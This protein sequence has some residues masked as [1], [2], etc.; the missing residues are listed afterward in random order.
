MA[1]QVSNEP[2][3]FRAF[4]LA[5]WNQESKDYERVF[6]PVTAQTAG[7]ILDAARVSAGCNLLDVC[8]GH[9][10]LALAASQR[11]AVVSAV[12]FAEAM[13]SAARRNVPSADCRLADAQALPYADNTFDAVV[14]GYGIPHVPQPDRALAEMCRVLRPGGRVAISVWERPSPTNGAGLLMGAVRAHG[15]LDLGLP[16]APDPFQF[17]DVEVM[18]A[19]LAEAGF[20]NVDAT[21]VEQ[22]LFLEAANGLTDTLLQAAVRTKALLVRQDPAARLAITDA[23]AQGVEK[24]FRCP[25]GFQ[26]PMTAVVGSGAKR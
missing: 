4:E 9:G 15:R 7:A 2:D 21:S 20:D 8:T 13:L 10:V 14:C 23:I 16:H 12:D 26:V 18:K 24:L 1:I 17:G 19:A 11:G 3:A 6:G 25:G 22:T 5:A